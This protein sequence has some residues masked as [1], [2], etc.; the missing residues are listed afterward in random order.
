[1]RSFLG[2][3]L[4]SALAV[5]A[6]PFQALAEAER[7][8]SELE[9]FSRR[10]ETVLNAD[11]ESRFEAVAISELQPALV[12]RYQ[13]FRQDFPAVTWRVES[14]APLADGRET[15]RLRVRGEAES[16]GVW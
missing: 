3:T 10:L 2:V 6:S 9:A 13:R 5:L 16:E 1:M 4:V 11:V 7:S 12:Q 14:A 15:L 8:H